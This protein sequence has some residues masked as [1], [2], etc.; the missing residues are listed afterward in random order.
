ERPIDILSITPTLS[1][2]AAKS[3]AAR[4]LL[5]VTGVEGTQLVVNALGDTARLAW[6]STVEGVGANGISRL[7]VDVDA[8]TGAVLREQEHVLQGTGTSAWNGPNPVTLNTTQ[9]GGTFSMRDPTITNLSCQDAANNTTFSGADDAWGNGD[10]TVR[11]TGCVD[12]LFG[13]QTEARML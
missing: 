7:T 4:Q 12:A 8:I 5:T 1:Q 6:E 11:E 10:A 3:I 2:A 13:A 9:S